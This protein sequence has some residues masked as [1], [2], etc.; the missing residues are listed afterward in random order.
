MTENYLTGT[1]PPP[2]GEWPETEQDTE[3]D[4]AQ[5]AKDQASGLANSGVQAGKHVS[6]VAR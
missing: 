6:D 3:Q 5:L 1:T 4:T 2:A